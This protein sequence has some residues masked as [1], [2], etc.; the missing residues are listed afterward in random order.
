MKIKN[1]TA[2]NIQYFNN[3]KH[4]RKRPSMY[5]GDIYIK[6]LYHL[7]YELIHNSLDEFLE[8]FCN[9]I[10]VIIHNNFTI[11]VKDNGRGIPIDKIKYKNK[12][13]S[14]LEL[15]M[16]KIGSGGKFDKNSYK[17]SSGLH[18]VGLSCVNALSSKLTIYSYKNNNIYKQKYIKGKPL[19]KLKKI[20]NTNKKGTKIKYTIDN[21]IFKYIK[22]SYNIIYNYLKEITYI[23]KKLNIYLLD[24]R[25]KKKKHFLSKKGLKNYINYI[26]KIYKKKKNILKKDLYY[27]KKSKNYELEIIIRYKYNLKENIISYVNNIK[28]ING[29]TH[30]TG[31]K[32]GLTKAFKK[33]IDIYKKKNLKNFKINGNDIREGLIAILVLKLKNP[34]FEGQIKNSLV[35]KNIIGLIDKLIYFFIDKFLEENPKQCNKLIEKTIFSYKTRKAYKQLRNIFI[36]NNFNNLKNISGVPGKLYECINEDPNKCELFLVE[37][38][39]AGGTAKQGRDNKFQAIL[40]LKGK[41]LNVIKSIHN[42]ILNNNEIKNIFLAL[43]VFFEKKKNKII[44]NIKNLKYKKIII[45]TDADVDGKHITTLILAFLY[46]YMKILFNKGYIYIA[47]PPLYMIKIKKKVN[48]LWDKK[49]KIKFIKKNK[50]KKMYIQRYKGL[51]EMNADQLW[52]TTMNPKYR[53]LKKIVIKNIIYSNKILNLLMGDN[54]KPRKKFIIKNYYHANLDI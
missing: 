10:I 34:Q 36:K 35:N 46:K 45:M 8:G 15:I 47:K 32:K 53:I 31:F 44:L 5:I 3:I 17:Y 48:Y 1:Y 39:S 20:K 38:D 33:H 54:V 16:T 27:K 9:K 42:K 22:Y 28:T 30:I 37:G 18:G 2:K 11:T 43:K 26:D 6:G 49:D 7:F 4:I 40:P 12:Y 50:N 41:I 19:Y 29:G 21:N 23:N 13:L 51:G 25:N 24:K 52:K 14:I